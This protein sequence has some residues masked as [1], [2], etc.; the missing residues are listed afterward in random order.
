MVCLCQTLSKMRF[1]WSHCSTLSFKPFQIYSK[2]LS[3]ASLLVSPAYTFSRKRL[4][5]SSFFKHQTFCLLT[6]YVLF[7]LTFAPSYANYQLP[8]LC[9][10]SLWWD[11][12]QNALYDNPH[13]ARRFASL[14]LQPGGL[15]HQWGGAKYPGQGRGPSEADDSWAIWQHILH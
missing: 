14:G 8:I 9:N 11:Y 7:I 6:N 1:L 12:F 15:R 10:A 5:T 13:C 3:S 2:S 4:C